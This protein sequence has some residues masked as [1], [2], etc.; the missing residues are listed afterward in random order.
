MGVAG[1]W[2]ALTSLVGLVVVVS[3]SDSSDDEGDRS[4]AGTR[5]GSS[6]SGPKPS[7]GEAGKPPLG[8][9]G[10][11]GAGGGGGAGGR[12]PRPCDEYKTEASCDAAGCIPTT[13]TLSK[14][15]P[16]GQGGEGGVG[17]TFGSGGGA[18]NGRECEV[19]EDVFISCEEGFGGAV[20]NVAC[21]DSCTECL[22]GPWTVGRHEPYTSTDC[23][24]WTCVDG[25]AQPGIP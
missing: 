6:G 25:T 9:G 22:G 17:G 3:C 14:L 7:A 18:L 12:A 21:N 8:Q 16:T 10:A 11:G 4:S 24:A 5:S 2:A 1:R 19:V 13:G 15:L 23:E 20:F